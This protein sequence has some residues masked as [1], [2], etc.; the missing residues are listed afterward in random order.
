[1]RVSALIGLERRAA[2]QPRV[3]VPLRRA[4][5]QLDIHHAA[6]P[7]REGGGVDVPHAR[8][9]DD[10]DLGGERV[11]VLQQERLE[12]EAAHLFLALDQH[13]HRAG[14][15]AGGVMPAAQ[16]LQPHHDLA[17]VV[18]CAAGGDAGAVRPLAQH[19]LERRAVPQRQR[20]GRLHVVVPVVQQPRTG[21]RAGMMRQDDGVARRCRRSARRSRSRRDRP[22]ASPRRRRNRRRGRAGR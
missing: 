3:Q 1:M 8:V 17:L 14:R 11:A 7:G 10:G 6:Q 20:L 16:R 22:A 4:Q 18:H 9:A 19:R 5:R 13:R 15:A 12:V 21:G 2:E